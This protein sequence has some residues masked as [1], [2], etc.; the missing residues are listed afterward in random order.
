MYNIWQ[1]W[2]RANL[3]IEFRF[4]V[5]DFLCVVFKEWTRIDPVIA[6]RLL[7]SSVLKISYVECNENA[8]TVRN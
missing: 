5:N 7:R 1:S 8:E 6:L 2:N 4:E 3:V